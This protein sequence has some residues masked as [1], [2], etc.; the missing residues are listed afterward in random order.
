ME[1]SATRQRP[2]GMNRIKLLVPWT[3]AATLL[4]GTT[5]LGLFT[6]NQSSASAA[7]ILD[8]TAKFF[9]PLGAALIAWAGVAR[10][11]D[12]AQRQDRI[13][14]WHSDL[15]WAVDLFT[16]GDDKAARTG[17]AVLDAIDDL[18]YLSPEQ[19]SLIDAV[20]QSSYAR[21]DRNS[22]RRSDDE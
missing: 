13:K 11:V 10:T 20:I 9:A 15:R 19:H 4:F 8:F 3:L 6:F 1:P 5:A 2:I 17:A 16:S 21:Y 18:S 14:E 22:E 12:N 7:L